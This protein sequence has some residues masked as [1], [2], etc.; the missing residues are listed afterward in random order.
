MFGQWII[1][2]SSVFTVL[3]VTT[4]TMMMIE[5]NF[6]FAS[7]SKKIHADATYKLVWQGFPVFIVGTTD[8][9]RQFHSFGIAVCSNEKSKISHLFF[10]LF[11]MVSRNLIYKKLIQ[12][13]WLQM[14]QMQFAMD[15]KQ[16][17]EKK[18]RLCVGIICGGRW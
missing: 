7:T 4:M 11:K 8:L 15:F 13:F 6:F 5:I 1:A 9:D 10:V 17:L 3:M 12:M 2:F 14:V 18:P 16:I